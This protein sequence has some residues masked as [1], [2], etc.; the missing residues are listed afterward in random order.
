MPT[1]GSNDRA[2]ERHA[3]GTQSAAALP[4]R[5]P[6]AARRTAG[7]SRVLEPTFAL[8][9]SDLGRSR[10]TRWAATAA[11]RRWPAGAYTWHGH[12]HADGRVIMGMGW[13]CDRGRGTVTRD[14]ATAEAPWPWE[15]EA[16]EVVGTTSTGRSA[17]AGLA[18]TRT[19]MN[20]DHPT[21]SA[22][23]VVQQACTT[24]T[25]RR[26]RC[27]RRSRACAACLLLRCCEYR[28]R[29]ELCLSSTMSRSHIMPAAK[30][31]QTKHAPSRSACLQ[32]TRRA[33]V[34]K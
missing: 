5:Q 22:R 27:E 1:R 31:C 20:A 19:P 30:G 3:H 17:V 6:R 11:W 25:Q 15:G 28:R 34:S 24:R 32:S 18:R 13:S 29:R 10:E 33:H 4:R 14:T 7:A 9:N 2:S 26:P 16:W 8:R 21:S 12:G 23:V